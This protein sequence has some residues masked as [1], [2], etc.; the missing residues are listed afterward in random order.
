MNARKSEKLGTEQ[1][2]CRANESST[3]PSLSST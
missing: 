3:K 1:N 2:Y